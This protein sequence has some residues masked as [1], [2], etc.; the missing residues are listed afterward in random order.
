[1]GK[2]LKSRF[3]VWPLDPFESEVETRIHV[4]GLVR[5]L[6]GKVNAT[7][8][9]VYVMSPAEFELSAAFSHPSIL[10]YKT[11]ATNLMEK[12]LTRLNISEL[13]PPKIL[14]EADP[15]IAKSVKSLLNYAKRREA[16]LIVLGTHARS[17]LPRAFL[18]SFAETVLLHSKLPMLLAGPHVQDRPIDHILFT[19]ASRTVRARF[20]ACLT[21]T[22]LEN[23]LGEF[24]SLVDLVVAGSLGD[25]SS[26]REKFVTPET[27]SREEMDFLKLKAKPLVLRRTK[28]EILSE[29][30]PKIETTIRLPFEQKQEK[31]YRDIALSWN[32]KVKDS[33]LNQG[34][35]KSQLLMLTALL[36]LRQACSDPAAIPHIKYSDEPPKV[37]VLME[38]LQEVT[39]S[40]ESALVFTQFLHTF[41]RIKKELKQ[42]NILSFSLHGGTSRVERE[43]ILKEFQNTPAGAVLLMT[44][45]TGGVGLN[46]IKASYV[47][48]LE[49]WW[50]PAVE[51]QASDRAHRIGQQ[52]PVQV[53]RYLMRGSVE[54]K[55]EILKERKSAKFNAL[56]TQ[57]E[58]GAPT[59]LTTKGHLS[60]S[61]FEYL[62]NG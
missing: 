28:A 58:N 13:L 53:Y 25:L 20:K 18:G 50:N 48:H 17:A 22:P 29:L 61:D 24:Y 38:A 4:T 36:R 43:R 45:K 14:V 1:M 57:T 9:P 56:F 41:D 10:E 59:E 49:P 47:F 19:T 21:G 11:I 27:I 39:E 6:I 60:Q 31:I 46:L 3:V 37:T 30:P 35:A 12:Y 2:N 32:E 51:S 15:S 40:G 52:K 8:E 33:I 26:F 34:E 5:Q 44:L 55:I 42:R 7:V 16:D 54:E 23:H 62:L